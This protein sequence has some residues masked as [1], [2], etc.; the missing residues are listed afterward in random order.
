MKSFTFTLNPLVFMIESD[1][2]TPS[3]ALF[4]ELKCGTGEEVFLLDYLHRNIE[5]YPTLD[6][7]VECLCVD[8][9]D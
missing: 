1:C 4:K 8:E 6:G 3:E 5:D 2:D 9:C 7:S